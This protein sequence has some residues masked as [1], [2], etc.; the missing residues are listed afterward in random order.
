MVEYLCGGR[1]AGDKDRSRSFE[2]RGGREVIDGKQADG[3]EA[4]QENP[5]LDENPN[6]G[7]MEVFDEAEGSGNIYHQ[8]KYS[9]L[10]ADQKF[11][12]RTEIRPM[13]R[14]A[15][16][17]SLHGFRTW[18]QPSNKLSVSRSSRCLR[19]WKLYMQPEM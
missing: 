1:V 14:E 4:R 5:K 6:F 10:I 8:E 16:C 15:R 11:V 19:G 2:V 7:I 13:D 3:I 9:G 12:G 18:C 17:G